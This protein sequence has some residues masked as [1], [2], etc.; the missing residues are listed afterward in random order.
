LCLLRWLPWLIFCLHFTCCN[1][2]DNLLRDS[3]ATSLCDA[4]GRNTTLTSLVLN[5]H[6][7]G[8]T[9]LSEALGRNTTLTSL[10]LSGECVASF[11][12][13][14]V[15]AHMFSE[16]FEQDCWDFNFVFFLFELN[17]S[18]SFVLV[19]LVVMVHF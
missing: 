11:F 7:D 9:S 10:D 2:S 3:G 13:F 5:I 8:V 12:V 1:L 18:V 16:D 15:V 6:E 14:F 4:L 17:A 19:A